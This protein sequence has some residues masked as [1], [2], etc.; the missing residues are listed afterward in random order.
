M[1]T[2]IP[3]SHY[4]IYNFNNKNERWK[5]ES[6]I[7]PL[8]RSSVRWSVSCRPFSDVG[9]STRR[10]IYFRNK[11]QHNILPYRATCW[12]TGALIDM[13]KC[14]FLYLPSQLTVPRSWYHWN[15]NDRNCDG[16][17]TIASLHP[18]SNFT[19]YQAWMGPINSLLRR[20]L[21]PIA[22]S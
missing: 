10:F 4:N 1:W 3:T 19:F 15:E 2:E 5:E 13:E 7:C 11:F 17:M 18:M 8:V 20:W 12:E 9:G 6:V 14:V 16:P 21:A 22:D